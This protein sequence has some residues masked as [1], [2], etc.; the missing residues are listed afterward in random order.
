MLW[1][2]KL[3]SFDNLLSLWKD[4]VAILNFTEKQRLKFIKSGGNRGKRKAI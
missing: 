3:A 2:Y 1:N 4:A